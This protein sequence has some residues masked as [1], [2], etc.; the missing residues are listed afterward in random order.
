MGFFFFHVTK[1]AIK[2]ILV[3]ISS[4]LTMIIFLAPTEKQCGVKL[5]VSVYRSNTGMEHSRHQRL[6]RSIHTIIKTEG[7]N[8]SSLNINNHNLSILLLVIITYVHWTNLVWTMEDPFVDKQ[9]ESM[10]SKLVQISKVLSSHLWQMLMPLK[11]AFLDRGQLCNRTV[12]MMQWIL[13]NKFRP[14]KVTSN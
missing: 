12:S 3:L 13:L 7:I 2:R 14:I 1:E 5:Q 6:L 11:W 4:K 9:Q 10:G 8:W